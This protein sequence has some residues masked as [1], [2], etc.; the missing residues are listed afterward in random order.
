[1]T[2]LNRNQSSGSET[3]T[4]SIE[5][6]IPLIEEQLN[7]TTRTRSTGVVRLEKHNEPRVEAVEVPLTSTAW[8]VQH[9][10]VNRVVE[11]TPEVRQEGDTTIYPV[12]EERLIV[13]RQ[14]VLRE[15]VHVTRTAT[16]T[17]NVST[18]VLLHEVLASSHED[19]KEARPL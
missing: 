14:L 19:E 16:T 12:M 15:E 9:V 7:V 11:V 8:K 4:R 2:N 1:M 13:T 6:T 3:D 17:T 18:H 10:A 5:G